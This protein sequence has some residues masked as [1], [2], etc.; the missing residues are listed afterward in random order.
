MKYQNA[1]KWL[2][3]KKLQKNCET[4]YEVQT[5]KNVK[6]DP[7]ANPPPIRWNLPTSL[8]QKFSHGDIQKD[9]NICFQGTSRM[10]FWASRNG[11]VQVFFLTPNRNMFAGNFVKSERFLVVFRG[12]II[13]N[14]RW[15]EVRK[16]SDVFWAKLYCKMGDLFC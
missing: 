12:H 9:T 1:E 14:V 5:A 3:L 15:V 2:N 10:Q 7:P 13:F 6:Y 4:F 11:T 16:M 8:E